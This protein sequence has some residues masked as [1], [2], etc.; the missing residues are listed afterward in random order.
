MCQDLFCGIIDVTRV[1]LVT[2]IERIVEHV[3]MEA[4]AH[5]APDAEDDEANC[6]MVRNQLLPGLRSFCSALRGR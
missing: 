1:G 5:P 6:P 2:T 3:F 4:L